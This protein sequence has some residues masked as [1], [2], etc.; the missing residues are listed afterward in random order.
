MYC[1]NGSRM[2]V[3]VGVFIAVAVLL[4]LISN[5]ISKCNNPEI[6]IKEVPKE[7]TVIKVIKE[8]KVTT[9]TPIEIKYAHLPYKVDKDPNFDYKKET[10]KLNKEK[11]KPDDPRLVKLIRNYY[12]EPPSDQPYKLKEPNRWD[13]SYGQAMFVDGALRNMVSKILKGISTKNQICT[14]LLTSYSL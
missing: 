10:E 2:Q 13:S 14:Y 3:G 7:T 8:T 12:I 11:V 9:Q 5:R 6:Q 4:L 1:S